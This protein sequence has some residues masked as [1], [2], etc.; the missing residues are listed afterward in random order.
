MIAAFF[1]VFL[2]AKNVPSEAATHGEKSHGSVQSWLPHWIPNAVTCS[3]FLLLPL[4]LWVVFGASSF[5]ESWR[6]GASVVFL[7]GI[8]DVLDG[9]LARRFGLCSPMGAALDASADKF[10]QFLIF[11]SL[12][13]ATPPGFYPAPKP[14]ALLVFLRDLIMLVGLVW[15][16]RK[17]THFQVQHRLH[18]KLAS[19]AVFALMFWAH[20][21]PSP[22]HG[23]AYMAASAIIAL[24]TM[25]YMK[26]GISVL[27]SRTI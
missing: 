14:F 2:G 24:S 11:T 7:L 16:W 22:L 17:K 21:P 25:L 12:A 1:A 9:W 19:L 15:I 10:C 18:G 3:R 27:R 6:G 23:P 4:W 8:T 13:F 5:A 26:D 20:W